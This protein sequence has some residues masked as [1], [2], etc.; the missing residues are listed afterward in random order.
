MQHRTVASSRRP[1]FR[2][3]APPVNILSIQSRVAYGHVGNAAAMFPLQRLGHEVW[4]IDTVSFSNHLGY[5]TWAGRV[6]M[7]E[8][9]AEI[10][11]GLERLDVLRQCDAVL[12]GY[13]GAAGNGSVVRDA[14]ERVRRANPAAV[15]ACDPV[16]GDRAGG[17]FVKPDIPRVFA[18]D[19][20]P[21]A[22]LALPNAFEL[23]QLSGSPTTNLESALAAADRLRSRMR[24]GA[25]VVVTGLLRADGPADRIESLAVSPEGAWLAATPKLPLP[26]NG[27]GDCFAALFLGHWLRRRDTPVA[28][29]RAVSAIQA[30]LTAT[31]AAGTAELQL[32]A[33]QDHFDPPAPAAHAKRVR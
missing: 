14:V 11:G 24:A 31:A 19:L 17:L 12:S 16:M 22:D 33:A 26:A 4:P 18:D 28:L 10:V 5:P 20:L 8:E 6:R 1:P 25:L 29:A 9:L 3:R 27:A 32:I 21:P 13:L 30:I 7:P 23:E 15:Y 2:S